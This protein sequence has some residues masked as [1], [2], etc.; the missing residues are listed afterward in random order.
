MKQMRHSLLIIGHIIARHHFT[1]Y[2]FKSLVSHIL[3]I[4]DMEQN[5]DLIQFLQELISEQSKLFIDLRSLMPLI[6]LLQYMFNSRNQ[7]VI[8]STLKVIVDAHHARLFDSLSLQDHSDI[9]LHQLTS[10][11]VSKSLL[12][13]IIITNNAPEFF[14][15]AS[16]MAMNLKDSGVRNF[17]NKLPPN[18][19][20]SSHNSDSWA[21]WL[22]VAVYQGNDNLKS[23]TLRYLLN[24]SFLKPQIASKLSNNY[25]PNSS[26]TS[27]LQSAKMESGKEQ[28]LMDPF[29]VLIGTIMIVGRALEMDSSPIFKIL[30]KEH[31]K[32]VESTNDLDI[33]QKYF[34]LVQNFLFFHN[35]PISSISDD[36]FQKS[37]FGDKSPYSS[38]SPRTISGSP[39]SPR[40]PQVNRSRK[41]RRNFSPSSPLSPSYHIQQ[42]QNS[43]GENIVEKVESAPVSP[44][45]PRSRRMRA[46]RSLRP[47]SSLLLSELNEE[48]NRYSPLLAERALAYLNP[49][50]A[51]QL[52][53]GN[54]KF[55]GRR[56]SILKVGEKQFQYEIKKSPDHI[57]VSMMPAELDAKICEAAKQEFN[58]FFGIR[59]SNNGSEWIDCEI[60]EQALNIFIQNPNTQFAEVALTICAFLMHFKPDF[61]N[62]VTNEVLS[63]VNIHSAMLQGAIKFVEHHR[64]LCNLSPI[65]KKEGWENGEPHISSWQYLQ[66]FEQAKDQNFASA[67]LRLMKRIIKFQQNNSTRAFDIFAM[68][69][70]DLVSASS[71]QIS[72]FKDYI[73]EGKTKAYSKWNRYLR[74]MTISRAPWNKSLK[75]HDKVDHFKRDP[76][77]CHLVPATLRKNPKYTDHK[78]ASLVRDTGSMITAE[79]L[80]EEYKRKLQNEY[81]ENAPVPLFKV[82][83][84]D[85]SN[86]PDIFH[87]SST[88]SNS[89]GRSSFSSNPFNTSENS[90]ENSDNIK[91]NEMMKQCIIELPCEIIKVDKVTNA[92][93]ALMTTFLLLT[94]EDNE[95]VT[96]IELKDVHQIYLRTRFHHP[97]AIELF[98]HN[99]KSYLINF[100]NVETYK[101]LKSFKSLKNNAFP[102]WTVQTTDFKDYYQTTKYT[103][104]WVQRKMSNFKYL[105]ILNMLSG[106]S[107]N[108]PSQYPFMPWVLSD[109]ENPKIDLKNVGV[110]RD[111][112]KPIGA[113][114]EERLET[115]LSKMTQFDSMGMKPYLFSSGY[116]CPLS[117]Y[118]W[119]L[120]EEPFATL[121][122]DIQSNRFDHASR[123]FY[124][125]PLSWK[126]ATMHQNDFRELTPEFY[127]SPEFLL[128]SNGYD[129]GKVDGIPLGD[130]IL[131][132]WASSAYDFI[133][134]NRKALESEYV[135]THLQKWID[136]VWGFK[137]TGEN[138]KKA[139]NLFMPQMYTNIWNDPENSQDPTNRAQIEAILWQVGQVPPQL[140]DKPHPQKVAKI[141]SYCPMFNPVCVNLQTSKIIGSA[142]HFKDGKV[143]TEILDETGL[144]GR[145][146]FEFSNIIKLS[147]PSGSFY[148]NQAN[149][150]NTPRKIGKGS[151]YNGYQIICPSENIISSKVVPE[152]NFIRGIGSTNSNIIKGSQ[153][154]NSNIIKGNKSPNSRQLLL[155]QNA[156]KYAITYSQN[157][158]IFTGKNRNEIHEIKC[159]NGTE[160]LILQQMAEIEC[161][162]SDIGCNYLGMGDTEGNIYIYSTINSNQSNSIFNLSSQNSLKIKL[163]YMI[164]S[165][166]NS[167]ECCALSSSYHSFVGGTREGSLL[168]CSTTR[169][170]ITRIIELEKYRPKAILITDAWGFIVVYMTE[171]DGGKLK[172]LIAVYS[173]NGELL[174]K[175]EIP[176]GITAWMSYSSVSG[177]D[178]VIFADEE[179]NIYHFEAFY[180]EISKISF[181]TEKRIVKLAYKVEEQIIVAITI[182]GY[183]L[184]IPTIIR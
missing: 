149:N 156:E 147:K 145:Y 16:W 162:S 152:F 91:I 168:T 81:E 41:S 155:Q 26:N 183:L 144:V 82:T 158:F 182:D 133:Y 151:K 77:L 136:L 125:I 1:A 33:E 126:T 128:N 80:Y 52:K 61:N 8:A 148:N 11:F 97:T 15:I 73:A 161:I 54:R 117:V 68:I 127:F 111:L 63:K 142:I 107:F 123:L 116:V 105:L 74:L 177:F 23:F 9:I 178:Y 25:L 67:P 14:I 167:I 88:S 102:Y 170:S 150:S 92:T 164:P 173:I 176:K 184:F 140:F 89:S 122:I 171:I 101:I 114:N 42:T 146:F 163:L 71:D 109:Y 37:C 129:L 69:T 13:E 130:V 99:G 5:V 87:S 34:S 7:N 112:S 53:Q 43:D 138:A 44:N 6:A 17:I 70:D 141:D 10:D 135:S 75:L 45:S 118:L 137:Q 21:F 96:Q 72:D 94:K 83:E 108:D 160:S 2:D 12:D 35:S 110:Y 104:K 40:S 120:R 49:Q 29:T 36:F 30:I 100:P 38:S 31:A 58:H 179:S 169:G 159:Q 60:G 39:R 32:I 172:H 139:N 84:S 86:T 51:L 157:S 143:Y 103:E 175:K 121:H 106:R 131:P 85:P 79:E 4:S 62:S 78:D 28:I 93:F 55:R 56:T 19:A 46:R 132:N 113:L 119:L 98:L 48:E 134:T 27:N 165:F 76:I 50:P 95:K 166:R 153:S 181:L 47:D 115:L 66:K 124:S 22:V 64:L 59:L 174:K 90:V 57:P 154:P 24:I 20:F 3:T 18:S 65:F 180:L